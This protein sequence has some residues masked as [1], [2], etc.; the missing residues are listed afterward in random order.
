MT[1]SCPVRWYVVTF[2]TPS[3]VTEVQVEAYTAADAI[4]QAELSRS[5]M[6]TQGGLL[7]KPRAIAV[8]PGRLI[9]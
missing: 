9:E 4:T 6:R 2:G 1:T 3:G 8:R 5:S 7:V